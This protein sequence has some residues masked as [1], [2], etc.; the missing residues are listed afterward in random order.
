[1]KPAPLKGKAAFYKWMADA[2]NKAYFSKEDVAALKLWLESKGQIFN[3]IKGEYSKHMS[4]SW[5]DWNKGWS[6]VKD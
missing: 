5:K 3:A 2:E 6:D 4:I 1:M